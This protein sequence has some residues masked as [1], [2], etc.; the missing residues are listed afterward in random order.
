VNALLARQIRKF[1]PH[2]DPNAEAWRS[3]FQAVGSAY[4]ELEQDRDFLEHTLEV[5]SDELTEA[6]EKLRRESERRLASVSRYYEQTLDLQQ[7]MILCL[8]KT[9]E[10]FRYTLCRGQLLQRLGFASPAEIEG[11]YVRDAAGPDQAILLNEAFQRAWDGEDV[12]LSFA[13]VDGIELFTLMRP[14]IEHGTVREIVAACMEVTALKD[15]ERELRAAKERAEAADRA[16]SEFLSVMSHEIRTPLNA[17]LGFGEILKDS[18]LTPEQQKWVTTICTSG[19]ALL[20]LIEDILDFSQIEAGR[21]VLRAEPVS[22]PSLL[23]ATLHLFRPRAAAKQVALTATLDPAVPAYISV[24]ALRLRQILVNLVGN[25]VKFTPRGTVDI[26]VTLAAPAT[27]PGEPCVL[28]FAVTDSGIG[29]PAERH[30]RL[31]KAFSQVDSS[32]TRQYGGT[33]LGLVISH[34]LAHLLGGEIGVDSEPGRGS[35]F[36]FTVRAPVVTLTR[37]TTPATR[38]V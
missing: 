2:V 4:T 9:P 5:T 33:G 36:F 28:R 32:S 18:P 30:E 20:A 10:G 12:S 26:A 6:N 19:E 8:D 35:T 38:S 37:G 22:L 1:L 31:F 13:T 21:L 23:E 3:F 29:I 11:K 27:A 17:V 14:R 15:A 34:R 16:K 25:A 7:G 24:D